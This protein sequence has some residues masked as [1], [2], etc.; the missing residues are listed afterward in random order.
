MRTWALKKNENGV[1]PPPPPTIRVN[2]NSHISSYEPM[3]A[4]D[5][6]LQQTDDFL[7]QSLSSCPEV[8]TTQINRIS[9]LFSIRRYPIRFQIQYLASSP[10]LRCIILAIDLISGYPV[11]LSPYPAGY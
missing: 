11:F 10:V 1:L 3:R 2:K 5:I 7:L 4:V 6:W 9:G 8:Q